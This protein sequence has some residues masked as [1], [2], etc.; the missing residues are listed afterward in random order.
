MN[1]SGHLDQGR[2]HRGEGEKRGYYLATLGDSN[3]ISLD[4]ELRRLQLP[5]FA[6]P[7]TVGQ[8]GDNVPT[9]CSTLVPVTFE[10][11]EVANGE[12]VGRQ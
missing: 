11:N 4:S 12:T 2:G 8:L 6:P 10:V 3:I 9:T 5:K 7:L 1:R